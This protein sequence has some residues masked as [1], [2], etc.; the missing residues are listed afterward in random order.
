MALR[1]QRG[2]AI[3]TING[4]ALVHYETAVHLLCGFSKDPLAEIEAALA[5]QPD[6]VMA[7]ALRGA[8]F[9]LSTDKAAE[10][11]LRR[12]VEAAEALGAK[13]NTRE[14]L[15]VT[16]IRAWLDGEYQRASEIY[17][18]IVID[19]PR[20]LLALFVG[21]QID[22]LLGQTTQLRDRVARVLP[23][24]DEH[25]PGFGFALGMLAFGLQ[26]NNQ[27]GRAEEMGRRAL[28]LNPRDAWA[29]HAVTHVMETEGRH[30]DGIAWLSSRKVDWAA[31]NLFAFHNWW[32]L[33]LFHLD[34][35]QTT[36]VFELY[37]T[38]IRPMPSSIVIETRDA[39]A[40][41]W[42][43]WLRGADCGERWTELADAWEPMA[44]D[45]HY[46]F[47]DMH[48][49]MAF[50]ATGRRFAIRRLLAAL[51]RRALGGGTN[52]MMTRDAGLPVC[53]ALAAFAEGEHGSAAAM[54]QALKP[55][56]HRLGGTH[57]QRDV[58]GLTLIE[59]AIRD[60]NGA[61]A[62]ALASER[63]VAKPSSPFNWALTARA[64]DL[65]GE[66]QGAA[67]ARAR[68]ILLAA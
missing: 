47:N 7:H 44:G 51:E 20:D 60:G 3:S 50:V 25:V 62:R 32:H 6:F 65:T 59:A 8:L 63:T 66:R 4:R 2:L 24:W 29:I 9:L 57:A 19:Y 53:R 18:Q 46:A 10:P 26:E 58:L 13:A 31:D 37:D 33:A 1:D 43:L 22:A 42:R 41:L 12:S 16:A 64:L 61:L 40:L 52:A 30:A 49:M 14:R 11:E 23:A 36:R 15:H 45:A 55:M 48:A 28:D 27:L 54:L 56:S 35:E 38:R 21:H 34:T 67:Q 17:G 5:K 39:T 68:A